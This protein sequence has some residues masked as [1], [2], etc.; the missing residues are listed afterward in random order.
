MKVDRDYRDHLNDIQEVGHKALG[1]VRGM[2]YEDFLGDDK[3]V[4]AVVRALEVLG[5]ATKR[6]PQEA[7]DLAPHI[8]WRSMAGIRDKLIHDYMNV[9]LDVVWKTVAEDIPLLLPMIQRLIDQISE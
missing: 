5:E 6:I 8:P 4:F 3:T 1:F 7:R 9:N 2:A